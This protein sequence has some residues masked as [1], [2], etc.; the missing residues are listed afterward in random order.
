M[1][2]LVGREKVDVVVGTVHSG[3]RH[4]RWL[5]VA[6]RHRHD[7]GDPECWRERGNG[8]DVRTQHLPHV[9]LELAGLPSMGKVMHDAGH[10]RVVTISWRYAAATR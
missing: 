6:A 5:K 9:L 7:A 4:W 1:N 3:R 10:R 8:A 2:R